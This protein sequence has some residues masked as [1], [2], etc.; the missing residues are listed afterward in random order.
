[1]SSRITQR[2]LEEYAEEIFTSQ[3][4]EVED[5]SIAGLRKILAKWKMNLSGTESKDELKK[6][7][8][9]IQEAV[10]SFMSKEHEEKKA[11]SRH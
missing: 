2:F 5:Y 6:L 4:M 11:V 7:Y 3:M 8:L 9:E 10:T 1:M